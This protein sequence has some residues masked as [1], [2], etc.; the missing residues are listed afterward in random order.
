MNIIEAR[1]S[2]ENNESIASARPSGKRSIDIL[3][4]IERRHLTGGIIRRYRAYMRGH[5]C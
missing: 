1:S 5:D 3:I 2:G 4:E